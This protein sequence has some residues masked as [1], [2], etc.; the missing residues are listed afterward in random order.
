MFNPEKMGQS[1]PQESLPQQ[2]KLPE[3]SDIQMALLNK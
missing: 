1:S 2:E 3:G